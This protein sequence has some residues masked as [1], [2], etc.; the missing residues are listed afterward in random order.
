MTK[1]IPLCTADFLTALMEDKKVV[2]YSGMWLWA[3]GGRVYRWVPEI[4]DWLP[5]QFYP[6]N[7]EQEAFL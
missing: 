2:Q 1:N 7:Q 5:I 6:A 4:D 3:K